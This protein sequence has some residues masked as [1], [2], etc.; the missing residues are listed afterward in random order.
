MIEFASIARGILAGDAM[1]KAAPVEVLA[2]RPMDPGKYLAAVTGDLAS[3]EAAVA[4]GVLA[5]GDGQAVHSFV[6]ANLHEQVLPVLRGKRPPQVRDAAGVIETRCAIA[7]VEAADAACKTA[8]VT[9]ITLR[10]ALR[11]GGKGYLVVTGDVADV[12]AAV[13]RGAALAG[14]RLVQQVVIPNPYDET[15]DA[16][17]DP[18]RAAEGGGL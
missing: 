13:E 16:L 10:L 1:V 15:L 11:I 18:D 3:V 2:L 9:L 12:E 6:L 17:L 14:P 7:A 8:P 5:A 4:A